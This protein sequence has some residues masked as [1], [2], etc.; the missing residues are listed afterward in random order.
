MFTKASSNSENLRAGK[1]MYKRVI[2]HSF[3]VKNIQLK[4]RKLSVD[5]IGLQLDAPEYVLMSLH[6]LISVKIA[7]ILMYSNT[8]KR[9]FRSAKW[10]YVYKG[11]T[12]L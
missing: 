2:V 11:Q 1:F 5:V 8:Q 7:F 10:K 4:F 3:S 6:F 9:V 12:L